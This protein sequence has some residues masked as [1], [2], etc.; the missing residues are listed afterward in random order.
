MLK[1]Y[2]KYS[3]L[4]IFLLTAAS[5]IA[6]IWLPLHQ[7]FRIVFGSV[8]VLFLPGFVWTWVVWK[9]EQI[10]PLERFVLSIALSLGV[11]PFTIFI[12]HTLGLAINTT[13]IFFQI[14]GIILIG[15][16]TICVMNKNQLTRESK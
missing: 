11:V 7:A 15:I 8:F 1:R 9:K 2:L 13:T 5:L 4:G 16:I 10:N 6:L 12:L 14:T 3:V